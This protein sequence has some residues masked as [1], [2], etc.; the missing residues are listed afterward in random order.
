M[1]NNFYIPSSGPLKDI[2]HSFWQT[3]RITNFQIETILPKGVVEIIF[4]F[5]GNVVGAK[6]NNTDYGIDKCII[7]GFN[8]ARIHVNLPEVQKFFGVRFHPVA[9]KHIFGIPAAEFANIATDL[10]MLNR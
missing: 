2:V 7:N 3:E 4:N 6:L 9:V 8:T 1:E 10:T 5:S